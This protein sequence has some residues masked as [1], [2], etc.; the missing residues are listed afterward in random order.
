MAKTKNASRSFLVLPQPF[1]L[2]RAL[3]GA[4]LLAAVVGCSTVADPRV[5]ANAT[6]SHDPCCADTVSYPPLLVALAEPFA[7]P[8][9][10][11]IGGMSLRSGY[12]KGNDAI[13]TAITRELRPLDILLTSNEGQLSSRLIPGHLTHAVTYLGT[14]ADLKALG[15]WSNPAFAPYRERIA[16]G[17]VF[18]DAERNGVRLT[19]SVAVLDYDNVVI[20]RPTVLSRAR[21]AA[22]ILRFARAVG[23]RFDFHFDLRTDDCVFCTELVYRTLPELRLPV[24]QFQNRPIVFADAVARIALKSGG[25]L[26]FVAYARGRPDGATMASRRVL[27][28]DIAQAWSRATPVPTAPAGGPVPVN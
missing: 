7:E 8:I 5:T 6:L 17:N 18:V 21:K 10:R 28:A 20:L 9:G 12:L 4:A 22:A 19:N 11:L 23:G 25:T 24:H 26:A 1:L 16:A 3:I 14:Q 13:R 2:I 27:A 15:V